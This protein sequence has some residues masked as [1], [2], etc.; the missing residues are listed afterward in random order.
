MI[1][2]GFLPGPELCKCGNNK[3]NVQNTSKYK[4][5][6]LCYRCMNKTCK[7]IFN[8][9]ENSFFEEYKKIPVWQVFEIIKCFIS[10]DFNAKKTQEYMQNEK[11]TNININ[12]IYKLFNNI[13]I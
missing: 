10:Y 9:R 12:V 4:I 13:R 1:E 6:S 7:K 3:F 2:I 5:S 8:I 11:N